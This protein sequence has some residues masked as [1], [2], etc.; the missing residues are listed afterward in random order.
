M[1]APQSSIRGLINDLT[2]TLTGTLV[3]MDDLLLHL[4]KDSG[5]FDDAWLANQQLE[6]ALEFFIELRSVYMIRQESINQKKTRSYNLNTVEKLLNKFN[7]ILAIVVGYCDMIQNDIV[8]VRKFS[9]IIDNIYN[10][11]SNLHYSLYESLCLTEPNGSTNMVKLA[12]IKLK[13]TITASQKKYNV[14]NKILLVEDDEGVNDYIS[15]VLRK[16]NYT[17]ICCSKGKKA[18]AIFERDKANI[19][20]CIVDVVLPDIEGPS[21][22]QKLLLHK[23]NINVLFT[24]GYNETKLKE[25]FSMMGLYQILIKPF[26]LEELLNKV[27]AIMP[28]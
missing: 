28:I 26:R 6:R 17:V 2:R 5:V 15:I 1:E 14:Y 20:L 7:N 27:R 13:P 16:H 8:D 3:H 22:V 11:I 23:P 4:D 19:G 21:L 9:E 10:S 18:L 25:H 12:S 24:S